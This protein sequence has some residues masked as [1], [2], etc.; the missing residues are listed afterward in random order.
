MDCRGRVR[1]EK[2]TGQGTCYVPSCQP[3]V[4]KY[5]RSLN[6]SAF[7]SSYSS[8]SSSKAQ[9]R[10]KKEEIPFPFQ[11]MKLLVLSARW[12]WRSYILS[13]RQLK[14]RLK[15]KKKKKT[16]SL[17]CELDLLQRLLFAVFADQSFPVHFF[18]FLFISL[19][20]PS[21]SKFFALIR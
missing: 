10:R 18:C 12:R 17:Q 9:R 13:S 8:L 16:V 4:Q 15:K 20:R 2:A 21:L 19:S 1:V 14:N 5:F 6:L 7:S 3:I 11:E